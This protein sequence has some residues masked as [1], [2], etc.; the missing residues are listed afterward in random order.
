MRSWPSSARWCA[1][2][3]RP[4]PRC[5]RGVDPR[6]RRQR[7]PGPG[8]R[9]TCCHPP[10]TRPR[11]DE[12]CGARVGPG[13]TA[14]RRRRAHR[15]RRGHSAVVGVVR[16]DRDGG[17]ASGGRCPRHHRGHR[18]RRHADAD[19]FRRAQPRCEGPRG[20]G[21]LCRRH[22][23]TGRA[24]DD[25]HATRGCPAHRGSHERDGQPA[26][27][28][29]LARSRCAHRCR[30]RE[31]DRLP[32]SARWSGQRGAWS[33]ADLPRGRTPGCGRARRRPCRRR[34]DRATSR[35]RR[36]DAHCGALAPHSRLGWQYLHRGGRRPAPCHACG[37]R[38]HRPRRRSGGGPR[39]LR[40]HRRTAAQR[41][42]RIGDGRGR[43]A[44]R[45][46]RH[47]PGRRARPRLRRGGPR[48]DLPGHGVV[49]GVRAL[50]GCHGRTHPA[51][52]ADG[53]AVGT[54]RP[55]AHGC[56]GGPRPHD[57]RA[58]RHPPAHRGIRRRP[59]PGLGARQSA[60]RSCGRARHRPRTPRGRCRDLR[61]PDRRSPRP[62]RGAVRRMDRVGGADDRLMA[63][64]DPPVARG[65]ARGTPR[66][67]RRRRTG[68][69]HPP[70]SRPS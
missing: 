68:L 45:H 62:V 43:A 44:R 64:R 19:E 9:P 56:R 39:G 46:H 21:E 60:R 12:C 6:A 5:P 23:G 29:S 2:D 10:G 32:G 28:R 69:R 26:R 63:R 17:A 7:V 51:R 20:V 8:D 55:G 57:R 18:H 40:R 70:S 4:D 25:P 61:A 22:L 38:A 59:E 11:A 47:P 67:G 13:P 14:L 54:G 3:E 27:G 33:P 48:R 37:T 1:S 52:G 36:P 49:V 31:R 65:A 41:A 16:R 24:G 50:R 35:A 42:A 30:S 53:V 58:G 34:R 66:H 15:H